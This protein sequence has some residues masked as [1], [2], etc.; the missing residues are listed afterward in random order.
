[1]KAVADSVGKP[2]GSL[3]ACSWR[4]LLPTLAA[5]LKF[6]EEERKAI[7]DWKYVKGK[8]GEAPTP[9]RYVEGREGRSR[10][11]KLI[12]AAVLSGL[13]DRDVHTLDEVSIQQWEERVER[14]LAERKASG[15]VRVRLTEAERSHMQAEIHEHE[16]Q[17]QE[18][19]RPGT[20]RKPRQ[21]ENPPSSPEDNLGGRS[22]ASASTGGNPVKHEPAVE[23]EGQSDAE[24][25]DRFTVLDSDDSAA[26]IFGLRSALHEIEEKSWTHSGAKRYVRWW[27]PGYR[28]CM[29][30]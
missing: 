27:Q 1:M 9:L 21:P 29:K 17:Q 8:G 5:K 25:A 6:Q 14:R 2:E 4:R 3:V 22:Q 10:T 7:G 28:G 30:Q 12:C 15:A 16:S 19:R 23:A 20:W 11:C 18:E 24:S 26:S 13:A